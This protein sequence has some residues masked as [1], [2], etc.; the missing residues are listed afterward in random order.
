MTPKSDVCQMAGPSDHPVRFFPESR[1]TANPT[2]ADV[3]T[4][5]RRADAALNANLHG[6]NTQNLS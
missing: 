6:L 3:S 4:A 2:F 1:T 5:D